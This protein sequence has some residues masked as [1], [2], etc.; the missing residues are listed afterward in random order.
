M[1]RMDLLGC[2]FGKLTVIELSEKRDSAG[3][4]L[5]KCKCS[6]GNITYAASNKLMDGKKKS[7]GCIAKGKI[8]REDSEYAPK[9][10]CLCFRSNSIDGCAGL[11]EMLCITQGNCKFYKS[12]FDSKK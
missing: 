8:I 3:A 12:K 2:S 6:C 1:K 10:D 9:T 11:T 7:C 5:W 4:R